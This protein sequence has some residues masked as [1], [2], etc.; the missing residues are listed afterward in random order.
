MVGRGR[1]RRGEEEEGKIGG[2]G[3]RE[4]RSK[5]ERKYILRSL[6]FAGT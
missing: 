6:L 4:S 3:G 1:R 5:E 2:E